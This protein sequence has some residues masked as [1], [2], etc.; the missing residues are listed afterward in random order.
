MKE[1][2]DFDIPDNR[3]TKD[4]TNF[5]DRVA[6]IICLSRRK[7]SQRE[8]KEHLDKRLVDKYFY[9]VLKELEQTKII[10]NVGSVERSLYVRGE[11]DFKVEPKLSRKKVHANLVG[12]KKRLAPVPD[13]V[14]D[15]AERLK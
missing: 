14:F 8:I 15:N 13:Y 3:Q 10:K 6:G 4:Y 9:D 12:G 1:M 5:R 7:L 11:G 2:N